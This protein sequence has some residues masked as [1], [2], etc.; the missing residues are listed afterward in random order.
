MS[1]KI[2]Y[3]KTPDDAHNPDEGFEVVV[4]N[5][6]EDKVVWKGRVSELIDNDR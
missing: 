4:I 5:H 1:T 2:Y 3:Q 6:D